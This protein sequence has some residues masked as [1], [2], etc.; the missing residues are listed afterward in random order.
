[1]DQSDAQA[2][3]L[4]QQRDSSVYLGVDSQTPNPAGGRK[5]VRLESKASYDQ[6]LI[7]LDL[8]HMPGSTC[9][10]WPAF[11]TVG[12]EW[13]SNGEI[14]IIEGV[15]SQQANSM[16]LHTTPG[17]SINDL[18]NGPPPGAGQGYIGRPGGGMGRP[19]AGAPNAPP[20][21][22]GNRRMSGNIKTGNCDVNAPGQGTNVGCAIAVQDD[23]TYGDGFNN[24]GGGVYATEWTAEHI[25]V[26]HFSRANI[27][28]GLSSGAPDPSTWGTPLAVFNG[29]DFKRSVANQTIVF[30][31]AFCGQWAGQQ[32]LWE[33]DPVCSQKAA[34]CQDYVAN[35]A[36]AFSNSFWEVNSLKVYQQQDGAAPAP[37]PVP[38]PSAPPGGPTVPRP[39]APPGVPNAPRPSAPPGAPNAPQQPPRP[40]VPNA[41]RPSQSFP[42]APSASTLSTIPV[43][44]VPNAPQGPTST[45]MVTTE[46]T[47]ATTMGSVQTP[48]APGPPSG[49]CG[50]GVAGGCIS[51]RPGRRPRPSGAIGRPSAAGYLGR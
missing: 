2:A 38:Q 42:D 36:D 7:V 22:A 6:G 49:A 13:P 11:W 51:R 21:G 24:A 45:I 26:Y 46:M 20:G 39:S 47:I 4:I 34:T 27:P 14:D 9:G 43:P 31:V 30:N 44:N 35:N 8:A 28:A 32:A 16:A 10:T 5:S 25:S 40:G 12:P 23:S 29:C 48:L 19:P 18:G 33:A 50:D 17:C 3:G 41:P 15:N 37:I 1:M